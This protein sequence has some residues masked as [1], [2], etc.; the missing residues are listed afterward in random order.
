MWKTFQV[1]NRSPVT[2][3]PGEG[4][5]EAKR[6]LVLD[7][8]SPVTASLSTSSFLVFCSNASGNVRLVD[9]MLNK[10][11]FSAFPANSGPDTLFQ[12]TK[13]RDFL[14]ALCRE[15]SVQPNAATSSATNYVIK[16]W[17]LQAVFTSNGG[18]M[19]DPVRMFNLKMPAEVTSLSILEDLTQMALGLAN[20]AVIV[21][22]GTLLQ[23]R[24][25]KQHVV[26]QK[27][28]KVLHVLFNEGTADDRRE[29][30]L[31][32]VTTSKVQYTIN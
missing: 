23:T 4:G 32:V 20:G 3:A 28:L 27:G 29:P 14:L 25:P 11:D 12:C 6:G 2:S 9:R 16:I 30:T 19:V 10:V 22:E 7:T 5:L 24:A 1:F 26:Q 15:P 17:D 31:F 8:S 13:K 21:L 18:Q